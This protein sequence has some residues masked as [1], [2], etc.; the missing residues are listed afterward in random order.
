MWPVGANGKYLSLYLGEYLCWR[1]EPLT[2]C[3]AKRGLHF[4]SSGFSAGE[5]F[6]L[7]AG[8]GTSQ[9]KGCWNIPACMG[10]LHK[11]LSCISPWRILFHQWSFHFLGMESPRKKKPSWTL[12]PT[13]HHCMWWAQGSFKGICNQE[14]QISCC[15]RRK[16][17]KTKMVILLHWYF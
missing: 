9:L 7:P 6:H 13:H 14:C 12:P 11:G 3:R 1:H 17:E 10:A 16:K 4:S 8:H 2:T 5:H 15:L